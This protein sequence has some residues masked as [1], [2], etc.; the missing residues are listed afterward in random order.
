MAKE[1]TVTARQRYL[2]MCCAVNIKNGGSVQF[3]SRKNKAEAEIN[4]AG[5]TNRR[6]QAGKSRLTITC[7]DEGFVVQ[8]HQQEGRSWEGIMNSRMLTSR[9]T[10]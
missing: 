6:E 5:G 8:F 10:C 9:S 3:F 7:K 4:A 2:N 1:L